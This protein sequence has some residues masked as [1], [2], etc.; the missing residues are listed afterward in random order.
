[1]ILAFIS[2][3]WEHGRLTMQDDQFLWG[4]ATS[5]HQIEGYNEKN[6]WWAWELKGKIEGGVR[7]GAATDHWNRFAE[8][9]RLAAELGLNS[10]RFSIEWSRIEPEEGKWDSAALDW[11]R[12]LIAE[13]EKHGL[14]PMLTLHH[15]TSPQWFAERGGFSHRGAAES[16]ARFTSHIARTLGPSV[17]LWCTVNEPMVLV[18]GAYLGGFMPPGEQSVERASAACHGLLRSHALA[19]RILHSEIPNRTGP[20]R[21]LPVQVG[22]AHNLLDFSPDR[23]WHPLEWLVTKFVKRFYNQ[24]WLDAVTGRRQRFGVPG[25]FPEIKPVPEAQGAPCTDFIGVNYYTKG[26]V[27][28]R[29]NRPSLG[30]STSL[31]IQ[32]AFARPNETASDLGWA[33][34]PEGIG[35]IL[36]EVAGYGLPIYVTESGIADREDKF[37]PDYISSHLAQLAKVIDEGVDVRGYYHW[38]LLDN[39]EWIKGFGPRFGLFEVNYDTF[40][41][42]PRESAHLYKRIISAHRR[43]GK[44]R[45]PQRDF[46]GI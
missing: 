3:F 37:R 6:D 40:A 2:D 41:R 16:F 12:A 20:W 23:S 30:I 27:Q 9:I 46:F 25:M 13:C 39:F 28:W 8:D 45:S 15:F 29:P 38:S 24:A 31:P 21:D 36:R 14:R 10:Y 1:M 32:I 33:I 19:Y 5:S 17:P 22:F 35:K 34:H 11:Y 43:G 26:Y 42:T 44:L 18:V 4:A 7:S